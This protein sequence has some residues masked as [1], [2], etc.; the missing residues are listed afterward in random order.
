MIDYSPLRRN[1]GE[2]RDLQ[3]FV[4]NVIFQESTFVQNEQRLPPALFTYGI[5]SVWSPYNYV[6][7][8][9]CTFTDNHYDEF[10]DVSTI[11]SHKSAPDASDRS[12]LT[13]LLPIQQSGSYAIRSFGARVDVEDSCFLDNSFVGFGPVQVFSYEDELTIVNNGGTSDPTLTCSFM[14]LSEDTIPETEEQVTCVP[15]DNDECKGTY[16]ARTNAPSFLP[17]SPP[18]LIDAP[19]SGKK[20]KEPTMSTSEGRGPGK[21]GGTM[22]KQ[23]NMKKKTEKAGKATTVAPKKNKAPQESMSKSKGELRRRMKMHGKGN[24]MKDT[25]G[26][27]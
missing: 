17:S 24:P 20:H 5:I 23:S 25:K 27:E 8:Q 19:V 21:A 22:R 15:F 4:Q 1:L 18:S 12:S 11:V 9:N 16:V 10:F 13:P 3:G 14:A 2:H 7:V 26:M 6:S